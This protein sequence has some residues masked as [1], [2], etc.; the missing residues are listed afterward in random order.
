MA[1]RDNNGRFVKG[2]KAAGRPK[3]RKSKNTRDVEAL[4]WEAVNL[5]GGAKA[6]AEHPDILFGQLVPRLLPKV[7]NQNVNAEHRH[8]SAGDSEGVRLLSDALKATGIDGGA[9]TISFPGVG[10]E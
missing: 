3:G 1:D 8:T 9:N 4:I 10:K 7:V 5:A 2:S 6:L